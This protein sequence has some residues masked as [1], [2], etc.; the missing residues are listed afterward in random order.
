MDAM[1]L[2][3]AAM[4]AQCPSQIKRCAG[5]DALWA[6]SMQD[7]LMLLYFLSV[8]AT[9]QPLLAVGNKAGKTIGESQ[10]VSSVFLQRLS[11]HI[12]KLEFSE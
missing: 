11:M 6:G 4:L 3:P 7:G 9:S 8:L 10:R 2:D 5:R 12:G 1:I